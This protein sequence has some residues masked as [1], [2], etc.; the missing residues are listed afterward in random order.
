MEAA[1]APSRAWSFPKYY[2]FETAMSTEREATWCLD[3]RAGTFV[4]FSSKVK[5]L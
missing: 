1:E 4:I 2:S 5:N 3:R